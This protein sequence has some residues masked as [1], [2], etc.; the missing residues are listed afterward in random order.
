MLIKFFSSNRRNKAKSSI[1]EVRVLGEVPITYLYNEDTKRVYSTL[2][3]VNSP[4][5]ETF[6]YAD[7]TPY[8][9]LKSEKDEN[10]KH[11]QIPFVE[12]IN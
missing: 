8:T 12:R 2:F 5:G 9:G 1:Y 3:Y 4:N 7:K 6:C 10:G 11:I